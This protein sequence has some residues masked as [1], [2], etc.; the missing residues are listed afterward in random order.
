VQ[1]EHGGGFTCVEQ[2][3]DLSGQMRTDS[4]GELSDS[5]V[6]EGPEEEVG[7][8]SGRPTSAG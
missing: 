1:A 4:L 7:N 5:S 2:P 6:I 8:R 3:V